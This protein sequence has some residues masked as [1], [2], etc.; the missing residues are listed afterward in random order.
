MLFCNS[1][2]GQNRNIKIILM[3]KAC[4]EAHSS[5]EE[6]TIKYLVPGHTFLPN[7]TD[8]SDV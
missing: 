7:D 5:L 2:G 8:F 6:I 1:C 4:L 3:L